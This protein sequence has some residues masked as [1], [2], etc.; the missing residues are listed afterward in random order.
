MRPSRAAAD[1]SGGA[2]SLPE[3]VLQ[4]SVLLAGAVLL[5]LLA[6]RV[7]LQLT[8]VLAVVGFLAAWLG[9]PLGVESPLRGEQFEEVLVFAFLPVLIFAAA[10]GIS[11]RAFFRNLGPILVLA[12][13]AFFISAVLVGIALYLGLAIPLTAALLFGA[14]ISATDPVA[15]VAI[16][17]QLGVPERLLTI[18]EGESMLNDGVAIVLFN[19]LLVATLGGEVSVLSGF[20]D[21]FFVFFGGAAIG[22]ALGFVVALVLPWLGRLAAAALSVAVAYG[23]FVLADHVLGFSGVMAAVA[24]GLVLGGLAPSRASTKVREA[25]DELWESLDYIANALLFLLIGLAID[26]DL[27]VENFGAIALAIIVVLVARAVAVVPLV[28]VLERFAG[29]PPVGRRNEAVLIWGGLRGGVALALALALPESLP[30]RETFVAMT[31]GV[32]LATLLLNATTI[33]ALV[34]RLGLD[35]PSRTE[36]FLA[37]VAR[38]SGIKAARERLD[39]L[40]LEDPTISSHLD[41]AERLTHEELERIELNIE[42]E[43]QVVTRRGLF[44]E[45][46]TYQHLSDAGL[47]R[48]PAMRTVLH[49]VDDQIEEARLDRRSGNA[50]RRRER[51]RVDRLAQRL[52]G[53]LPEPAG[54]DPEEIAYAEASARRL[55]ARRA[56]EALEEL[57][58]MPGIEEEAVED[59]KK[60]FDRWE[61]EAIASLEELNRRVG[62][63][64]GELRRHQAEALARVASAD[65]VRELAEVG[66]LPE[67]IAQRAAQAV[68]P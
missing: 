41:D 45:R 43:R 29:I 37:G 58:G 15:V 14:L 52:T 31:G 23:S 47:L 11:T 54:E 39:D 7:R 3:W 55:A 57:E 65:K 6:R 64:G 28:S 44:V 36:R 32:V 33:G 49:E 34:H 53:W 4:I 46:E 38:L 2:V 62:H 42:E 30:E 18:V 61:Q 26:P 21:F 16:F 9:G 68:T 50:L 10:L 25:W 67:V 24:A 12:I 20:I 22:A 8:V 60:T 59:A 1:D 35:E 17:R 66:L 5:G 48:P 13:V 56:A 63:G 27:I 51:P 19:I 40:D